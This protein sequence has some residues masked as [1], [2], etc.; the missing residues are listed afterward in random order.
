MLTGRA[1]SRELGPYGDLS[2]LLQDALFRVF[3]QNDLKVY[4]LGAL[5]VWRHFMCSG[6]A[7]SSFFNFTGDLLT[8]CRLLYP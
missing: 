8:V 1:I 4:G 7:V 5:V 3:M 6:F 2:A